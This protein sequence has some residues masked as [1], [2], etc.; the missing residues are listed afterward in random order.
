[1]PHP[2]MFVFVFL[3]KCSVVLVWKV[4]YNTNHYYF[5]CCYCC[6]S[7]MLCPLMSFTIGLPRRGSASAHWDR[8]LHSP[9]KQKVTPTHYK[10][11]ACPLFIF[12]HWATLGNGSTL[13]ISSRRSVSS[14][15]VFDHQQALCHLLLPLQRP[16]P[17]PA[18]IVL[19]RRSMKWRSPSQPAPSTPATLLEKEAPMPRYPLNDLPSRCLRHLSIHVCCLGGAQAPVALPLHEFGRRRRLR[20]ETWKEFYC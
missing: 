19:P 1:M 15:N 16:T 10:A 17:A 7:Y 3:V 12:F 6:I 8:S 13:A 4:P 9:P 20:Q 2:F 14:S 5:S 18:C 11:Q